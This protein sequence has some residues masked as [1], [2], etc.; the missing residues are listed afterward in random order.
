MSGLIFFAPLSHFQLTHEEQGFT[1]QWKKTH[2]LRH[3]GG[4]L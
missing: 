4:Y 3:M 1:T 2:N